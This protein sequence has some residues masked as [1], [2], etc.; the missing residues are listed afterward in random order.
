MEISNNKNYLLKLESLV[1]HFYLADN[2]LCLR[3]DADNKNTM[4]IISE[5]ILD[6]SVDI[7]SCDTVN[8]A[9]IN[10][11]GNLMLFSNKSKTWEKRIITKLYMHSYKYK[12]IKIYSTKKNIHILLLKSDGFK[13]NYWLI[14]HYIVND[15]MWQS[16]D[17]AKLV[18]HNAMPFY[19]ADIDNNNNLHLI[20]KSCEN[21][22]NQLFYR[23]FNSK[24]HKWNIVEKLS[25]K[26]N[27]VINPNLLCDIENNV[28][29]VWSIIN[30]KNIKIN[31]IKRKVNLKLNSDWEKVEKFPCQISNLTYPILLQHNNNIKLLWKQNSKIHLT[32][33]NIL[34]NSWSKVE[35][36]PIE[37]RN[38]M[39]ISF[40]TSKNK[41]N[42]TKAPLTYCLF[43]NINMLLFG[44][45]DIKKNNHGATN[46]ISQD[47]T[48]KS[49]IYSN[50]KESFSNYLYSINDYFENKEIIL[51]LL[52]KASKNRKKNFFKEDTI[53]EKNLLDKLLYLYEELHALKNTEI[54][55]LNSFLEMKNDYNKLFDKVEKIINHSNF[56]NHTEEHSNNRKSLNKIIDIF[57]KHTYSNDVDQKFK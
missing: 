57:S 17:I 22:N 45:D 43:D 47:K 39:P 42:T 56:Q 34:D 52:H 44:I 53:N 23:T 24:Y 7:N 35:V 37:D 36:I 8:I 31:F 55:I 26:G 11:L 9:C 41:S 13:N 14:S 38:L 27:D 32:S 54:L 3:I 46:T 2:K 40:I 20:Y 21:K 51:N 25:L 29:I 30:N 48:V 12:D 6:F 19:K 5:N 33:T 10:T 16:S 50:I 49:D 18:T 28:Y 15:N 1:Y 4:S